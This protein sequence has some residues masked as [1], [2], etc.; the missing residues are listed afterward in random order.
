MPEV[1][2]THGISLT[3][4]YHRKSKYTGMSANELK[5]VK[6]LEVETAQRKRVYADLTVEN[7]AVEGA[8]VKNRDTD[9]QRRRDADHGRRHHLSRVCACQARGLPRSALYRPPTDRRPKV[10][11]S[12]TL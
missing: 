2:R 8:R 6:E 11:R 9:R 1:R 7:A 12:S 4:Y 10:S 3:T 5:R